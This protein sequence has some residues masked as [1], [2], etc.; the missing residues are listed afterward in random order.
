MIC[1]NFIITSVRP[2]S[3]LP[4]MLSGPPARLVAKPNST[5]NT[6]R[7]SMARRLSRPTKSLAVKKLTIMSE[8]EAYSP[9]SSVG[10]SVQGVSTG[11][12]IFIRANMMT[13][14][15]APVIT[16]VSTVVPM[17]LPARLRLR[18][19]ATD[20]AMEAKTRGTTTQNIMLMNTVPRGL[21]VVPNSGETQPAM[22][23]STMAPSMMARNR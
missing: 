7:G 21:I 5:E 23:P 22:Q 1:T 13:A 14:A 15:M 3:H 9:S 12:K 6:I 17:I 16:K 19:L 11:G 20:P 4:M 2:L 10:S 18:M 8:M